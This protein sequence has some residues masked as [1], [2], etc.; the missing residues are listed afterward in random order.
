[1]SWLLYILSNII[2]AAALALVAW[3]VQHFLRS[4]GVARVL[5]LLVII[6]LVT[7]PLVSVPLVDLPPTFACALG[8]CNCPNHAGTIVDH[9]FLWILFATWS[10]GAIVTAWLAYRR[11]THF[12][13][14]LAH[15]KPAPSDWQSLAAT[16]S[17]ELKIRCPEILTVPGRL[18]PLVVPN[19]RRP[20]MLL[21]I[22]LINQLNHSQ[23]VSLLLHELSHIK[24]RDH[25]VRLLEL[26]V[27]VTYWWLPCIGAISRRL[28]AC[29]ETCSDAAVVARLPQARRDY[30]RLLLDVIDFAHPLPRQ[31]VPQATA[32]SA[33]ANELEHRLRAILDTTQKSPRR[34]LAAALALGLG[35]AILP[36]Q[37]HYDLPGLRPTTADL[38]EQ[39]GAAA[40]T[41]SPVD[42]RTIELSSMCC[43]S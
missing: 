11:W 17:S 31:A 43:P 25:L 40:T 14:I 21:P 38:T 32:M 29:E 27:N 23:R 12:R 13:R 24:R 18:P 26:I 36:C 42:I 33:A 10:A 5:W 2:L 4:P 16:L 7:P 39:P 9:P 1:M 30:A 3:F 6:K 15:A 34:W 19:R 20:R 28:R 22:A 37:L 35:C 8:E 41:P